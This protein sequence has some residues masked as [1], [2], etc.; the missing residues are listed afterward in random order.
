MPFEQLVFYDKHVIVI[1]VAV[2]GPFLGAYAYAP[3]ALTFFKE[4]MNTQKRIQ[5]LKSNRKDFEEQNQEK[6]VNFG[7]QT[8]SE[9]T[10]GCSMGWLNRMHQ[11]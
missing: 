1:G 9:R 8:L 6:N 7:K 5:I 11:G 2:N 10:L 3:C 4:H